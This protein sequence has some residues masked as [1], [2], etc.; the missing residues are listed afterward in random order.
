MYKEAEE[1][2]RNIRDTVRGNRLYVSEHDR[3]DFGDNWDNLRKRAFA[4]G[5]YLTNDITDRKVDRAAATVS[6]MPHIQFMS[7]CAWET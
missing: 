5:I 2:F 3:H 6:C 1:I 4:A 7:I